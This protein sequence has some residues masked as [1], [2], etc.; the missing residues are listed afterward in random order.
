MVFFGG[1]TAFGRS[2]PCRAPTL[3]RRLEERFQ[4]AAG[5]GGEVPLQPWSEECGRACWP[6]A[7][8]TSWSWGAKL[9][10]RGAQPWRTAGPAPTACTWELHP[11]LSAR[12]DSG[13]DQSPHGGFFP[14]A[15]TPHACPDQRC[16][17]P[18]AFP[19][20]DFVPL[21]PSERAATAAL[22]G[23]DGR[24]RP[25][26]GFWS[27]H[28]GGR[29]SRIGHGPRRCGG[30]EEEEAPGQRYGGS[31]VRHHHLPSARLTHCC[32]D[33]DW[34]AHTGGREPSRALRARREDIQGRCA[35]GA[36]IREVRRWSEGRGGH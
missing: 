20:S 27:G 13:A 31:P 9:P 2:R 30:E 7:V 16:S 26:L 6:C 14:E 25:H 22:P 35:G 3:S 28:R 33:G 17:S 5:S 11:A 34:I 23:Q 1:A 15:P 32:A 21:F 36:G 19:L 18:L 24:R 10:R 29:A 8:S 4:P 12:M